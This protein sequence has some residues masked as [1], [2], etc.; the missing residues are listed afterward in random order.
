MDWNTLKLQTIGFRRRIAELLEPEADRAHII[1]PA[2]NNNLHWHAGHLVVTPHLL[3]S[4]NMGE[5][6]G[7]PEEYRRWFAKGSS[8]RSW[9]GEDIPPFSSLVKQLESTA[10]EL[11]DAFRDRAGEEFPEP[12]RTSTGVTL[13]T[14]ADALLFS[15]AHD[16]F[17]LGSILALLRALNAMPAEAREAVNARA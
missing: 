13:H 16:G 10:V 12:F 5:P 11:F 4:D 8:P 6:I 7:V 1:P 15:L 9:A 3:T 2:W 17:H 14:P